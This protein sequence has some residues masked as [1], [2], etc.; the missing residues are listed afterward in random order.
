MNSINSPSVIPA[1]AGTHIVLKHLKR[2][3]TGSNWPFAERQICMGP[4]LCRD[5][6]GVV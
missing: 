3:Y 4:G 5:D 1:K 2:Q 6:G